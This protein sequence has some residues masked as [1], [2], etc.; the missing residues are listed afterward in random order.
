[1]GAILCSYQYLLEDGM[2]ACQRGSLAWEESC[3]EEGPLLRRQEWHHHVAG[4]RELFAAKWHVVV[5][6]IVESG[7]ATRL[8]AERTK[9][10]GKV[11]YH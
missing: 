3:F 1:M 8:P 2:R 5:S 6:G 11:L 10:F 9:A 7:Q 4:K